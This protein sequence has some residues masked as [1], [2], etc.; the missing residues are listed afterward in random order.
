MKKCLIKFFS[1]LFL[2]ILILLS[3]ASA[4][5][6]AQRVDNEGNGSN[7]QVGFYEKSDPPPTES[8]TSEQ[9]R[10]TVPSTGGTK[11]NGRL[12]QTGMLIKWSLV[13]LGIGVV[14][15]CMMIYL[16]KLVKHLMFYY[17]KN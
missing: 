15:F 1:S 13:G 3:M 16:T 8:S 4:G 7:A 11:P 6:G 9:N 14:I 17:K 12:P 5:Y 10:S 2:S